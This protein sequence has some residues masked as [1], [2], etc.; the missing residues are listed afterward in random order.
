VIAAMIFLARMRHP[1]DKLREILNRGT[2][3][4]G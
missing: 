2:P 1:A 4:Q 3:R